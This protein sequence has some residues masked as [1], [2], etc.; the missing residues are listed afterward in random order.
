MVR[1]LEIAA[2]VVGLAWT[3]LAAAQSSSPG[4]DDARPRF[5]TVREEGKQPQRCQ[6]LKSWREPNGV[7]A[8]QARAVNSGELMT[9]VGSAPSAGGD[10]RAMSTRIFHWSNNTPPVGAPMPPPTALNVPT[11]PPAPLNL[12]PTPQPLPT[13]LTARQPNLTP[14]P[15]LTTPPIAPSSRPTLPPISLQPSPVVRNTPLALTP[16]STPIIQQK[17]SALVQTQPSAPTQPRLTPSANGS[18]VGQT[19]CDCA[20]P[21]PCTTTCKPCAPCGQTSSVCCP[22]SPMRQSFIGRLLKPKPCCTCT[23]VVCQPPPPAPTT[24]PTPAATP[25]KA[26]VVQAPTTTPTSRDPRESWGKVE[27]WKGTPPTVTVKPREAQPIVLGTKRVDP[28]PVPME[29]SSHP[30]PLKNP[31]MYRDMAM[32]KVPTNSTIVLESKPVAAPSPA[33]AVAEMPAVPPPTTRSPGRVVELPANEG[34]AFW[35]PPQPPKPAPEGPKFNAFDRDA[36]A[37]P[38][39]NHPAL[40]GMPPGPIPPRGPMQRMPPMPPPVADMGIPS[41][42]G[43]AFTVAGTRR[44]IP[45]DFGGTP[46]GF[47]GFADGVTEGEGSPPRSYGMGMPGM[48]PPPMQNRVAM[49]PQM[50]M[51]LNPLMSV[52]PT[53]V[54]P[55]Q[56][57]AAA[58]PTDVPQLLTTLKDSVLPSEREWAAEQLSEQNWHAQPQV[59]QNLMTAAQ[60]DPAATVRATCVH[61]LAHMQAATKEVGALVQTLKSDRDPRV[62]QE[63]EE[64]ADALGN[65]AAPRDFGIQPASHR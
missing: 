55:A 18:A 54:A 52:P 5:I 11:T 58:R 33:Q 13:T 1:S 9:I 56:A 50:P 34:N 48:T 59:V 43:N 20:C 44:P 30:N 14:S 38:Q 40:V 28:K 39:G 60:S 6:L 19:P 51:G 10:P 17:P 25:P 61:A 15:A 53:P 42:M 4:A 57:V 7:S 22:P 45:A 16:M 8:F 26:V 29:I 47:N 27:P 32:S 46:Q 35:T 23:E 31:E 64:A 65:A 36:N 63:A 24:T 12:A 49:G 41:G 21:S 2:V 37:P 62:R 3:G